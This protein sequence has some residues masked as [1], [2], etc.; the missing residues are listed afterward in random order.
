M[1]GTGDRM[2]QARH[3]APHSCA[4]LE[5]AGRPQTFDTEKTRQPGA[6][7]RS[8]PSAQYGG[9]DQA[10]RHR[11]HPATSPG[12]LEAR[13]PP[14]GWDGA[15]WKSHRCWSSGPAP[16]CT[17]GVSPGPEGTGQRALPRCKTGPSRRQGDGTGEEPQGQSSWL[18]R[19]VLQKGAV[20]SRQSQG[21]RGRRGSGTP[22]AL[23]APFSL[24]SPTL[25][26]IVCVTESSRKPI[27]IG[28]KV[29]WFSGWTSRPC[30]HRRHPRLTFKGFR[31]PTLPRVKKMQQQRWRRCSE[32]VPVK[33][34]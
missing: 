6:W 3:W 9:S 26:G 23:S 34:G 7:D 27:S 30:S 31:A 12:A 1:L 13:C 24:P 8:P 22:L 20:I 15:I 18:A 10:T 25:N 19:G 4:I 16:R 14:P 33:F 28:R 32:S 21:R 5:A 29:I 2:R 11:G 17:S